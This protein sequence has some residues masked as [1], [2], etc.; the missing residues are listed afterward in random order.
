MRPKD[1]L[2]RRGEGI[3]AGYLTASGLQVLERNWRCPLGEIDIVARDGPVFVI[4]EVKTRSSRAYGHPFEAV[5][6]EKLRRLYLLAG[7]WAAEHVVGAP[8]QTRVD[9]VGVVYPPYG[10]PR[11]EHIKAVS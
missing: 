5:T 7:A 2:G 4:V 1:E 11:V 6:P 8:R 9:V 3:A 10:E